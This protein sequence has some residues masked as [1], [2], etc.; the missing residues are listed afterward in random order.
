MRVFGYHHFFGDTCSGS[1]YVSSASGERWRTGRWNIY[2]AF[3]TQGSP[4]RFALP[5]ANALPRRWRF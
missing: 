3:E 2:V 1:E 5:W 4:R